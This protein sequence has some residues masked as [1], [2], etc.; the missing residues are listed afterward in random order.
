MSTIVNVSP[1]RVDDNKGNSKKLH[2]HFI[3]VERK[4]LDIW[5]IVIN[6]VVTG[7]LFCAFGFGRRWVDNSLVTVRSDCR[8]VNLGLTPAT[9][10]A[11]AKDDFS[12]I[13]SFVFQNMQTGT[14]IVFVSAVLSFV[15]WF[16]HLI[17]VGRK[18]SDPKWKNIVGVHFFNLVQ[19]AGSFVGLVYYA[20]L[21]AF[22]MPDALQK[23]FDTGN[24][25][26]DGQNFGDALST[27]GSNNL[28]VVAFLFICLAIG[29]WGAGMIFFTALGQFSPDESDTEHKDYVRLESKLTSQQRRHG[30]PIRH[31]S[32]GHP[33]NPTNGKTVSQMEEGG[34]Y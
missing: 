17:F 31:N 20:S 10:E 21:Q 22:T 29:S 28:T 9:L 6:T 13:F 19:I 30:V 24:C 16:V 2:P 15:L 33:R 3:M 12:R 25:G 5:R 7:F 14:W 34:L 23:I 1:V 27:H 26:E 32:G 4:T 8:N 11:Q 18:R